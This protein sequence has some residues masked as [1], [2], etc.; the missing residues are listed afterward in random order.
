MWCVYVVICVVYVVEEASNVLFAASFIT[1]NKP[2]HE[3]HHMTVMKAGKIQHTFLWLRL[4]YTP[5]I[6]NPFRGTAN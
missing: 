1:F 3:N 6:H 2:I 4:L 5:D